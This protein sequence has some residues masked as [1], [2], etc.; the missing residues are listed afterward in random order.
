MDGSQPDRISLTIIHNEIS[1]QFIFAYSISRPKNQ[2]LNQK[3]LTET[4][5]YVS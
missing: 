1:D 5:K 2:Y 4:P 3:Y